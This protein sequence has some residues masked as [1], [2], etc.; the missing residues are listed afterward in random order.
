M[1]PNRLRTCT[2]SMPERLVRLPV[3]GLGFV[4]QSH[5]PAD[6][7]P[8]IG[9]PAVRHVSVGYCVVRFSQIYVNGSL[10]GRS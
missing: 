7:L 3:R 9:L 6:K 5:P 1:P 4:R 2:V 10:R 8:V